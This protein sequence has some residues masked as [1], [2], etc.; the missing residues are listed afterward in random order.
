MAVAAPGQQPL[1]SVGRIEPAE[2]SGGRGLASPVSPAASA[3][4]SAAAAVPP[5][6]AA[7][8]QSPHQAMGRIVPAAAASPAASAASSIAGGAPSTTAQSPARPALP[9]QTITINEDID[10][11]KT[12]S[13]LLKAVSEAVPGAVL[14]VN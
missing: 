7:G 8:H 11:E 2:T 14:N 13:A 6:A 1:S 12:M 3:A 10:F 5:A 9:G 4:S